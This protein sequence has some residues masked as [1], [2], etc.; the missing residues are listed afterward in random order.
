MKASSR[1]WRGDWKGAK[2]SAV[3]ARL[4]PSMPHARILARAPQYMVHFL[5]NSV[6]TN[7]AT[8]LI[9]PTVDRSSDNQRDALS[10]VRLCRSS[11]EA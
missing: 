11:S 7:P 2:D 6:Q 10:R 3:E 5:V 8:L 9:T 1:H 4:R